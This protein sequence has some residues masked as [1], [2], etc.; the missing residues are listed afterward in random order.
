MNLKT[1]KQLERLFQVARKNGVLEL[2]IEGLVSF[3]L[4]DLPQPESAASASSTPA[5][6]AAD[7]P[8]KHFPQGELTHD[9]L[10][11]YS[12][13]GLPENDPALVSKAS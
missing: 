3:K 2:H 4:G 9:Q 7:D 11:Y 1:S 8:L 5:Q 13:G 12:A 6:E 10:M